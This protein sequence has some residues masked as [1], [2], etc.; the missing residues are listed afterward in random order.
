VLRVIARAPLS[1]IGEIPAHGDKPLSF[2]AS[3][4]PVLS[5]SSRG[6]EPRKGRYRGSSAPGATTSSLRPSWL[7]FGVVSMGWC[8]A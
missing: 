5:D 4:W 2:A 7:L 6:C 8:T 1:A 3:A